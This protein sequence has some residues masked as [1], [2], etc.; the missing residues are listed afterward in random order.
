MVNELKEVKEEVV[1]E[2]E[3][4]KGKIVTAKMRSKIYHLLSLSFLY[5]KE[6][7]YTLLREG[8][9]EGLQT[10]LSYLLL[11]YCKE[12]NGKVEEVLNILSALDGEI[13]KLQDRPVTELQ[14]D[15][16]KVFGHTVSQEC[17]PY[18]T[19][20]GIKPDQLFQKSNEMGDIAGF[21]RAFGLDINDSEEVRE[22]VDHIS[23]EFEF[24]H[25]L[26]CKEAYGM[27][28]GDGQD[29]I[30]I[31]TDAQKKFIRDHIAMWVPL[32]T[33][34]LEKKAKGG[35]YKEVSLLT[36]A[37]VER[38][39]AYLKIKPRRLK[40]Q[41]VAIEPKEEEILKCD[42]VS[43]GGMEKVMKPNVTS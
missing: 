7:T 40:T 21:Y 28:K 18:E 34:Y 32:F 16:V 13:K 14:G 12:D 27:E 37:F 9:I 30:S 15:Y 17:P 38:E 8:F 35:F 10:S 5:P 29:K 41:E 23:I 36:R 26:T 42:D 24:M 3:G 39:I 4:E 22:R 2:E 6:D 19:Q 20:Y 11:N 31:V 43:P 25:F 33:K 1:K